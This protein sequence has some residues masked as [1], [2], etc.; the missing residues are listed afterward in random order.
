MIDDRLEERA[1][2]ADHEHGGVE[3]P[4]VV[5]EPGGGLE[6]EVVGGLVQ[7]QHVGRCH[8][9][10]RQAQAP[11]LPT[12]QAR[13]LPGPRVVRVEPQAVEDG[14]DARG[15]RVASLAIEP[16]EVAVVAGEHLRGAGVAGLR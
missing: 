6:V 5:L 16:L 4:Q 14:V 9:L 7:Q 1:V 2:V 10:L 13:E 11:A 12:A 3:A 15:Q 8:E